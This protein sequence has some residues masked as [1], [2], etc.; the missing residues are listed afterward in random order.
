M[1]DIEKVEFE[2]PDEVEAKQGG[3][4]EAKNNV[5]DV[6][7]DIIDDTPEEDRGREPLPKEVVDELDKDELEDY[8]EK[9]KKKLIIY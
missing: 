2:F 9:V 7:F 6:D 4:V 1:A 5:E 8:S 3:K